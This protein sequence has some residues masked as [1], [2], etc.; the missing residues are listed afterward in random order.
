MKKL[1]SVLMGAAF[2]LAIGGAWGTKAYSSPK[3]ATLLTG[4]LNQPCTT[5]NSPCVSGT[6]ACSQSNVYA[7][8][9]DH[10]CLILMTKQP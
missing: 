8:N 7:F 1:S 4:V 5:I 9:T 6:V 10:K 2:I 3:F